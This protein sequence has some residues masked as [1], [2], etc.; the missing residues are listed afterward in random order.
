MAKHT[1]PKAKQASK[2]SSFLGLVFFLCCFFFLPRTFF[3]SGIANSKTSKIILLA[4]N[5]NDGSS[6]KSTLHS[7]A[8]ALSFTR[9][10]ELVILS[11]CCSMFSLAVQWQPLYPTILSTSKT[12]FR[13][14]YVASFPLN[15]FRKYSLKPSFLASSL[16]FLA[17]V[18][19]SPRSPRLPL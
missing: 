1:H 18:G 16:R 17:E 12:S 15:C 5:E 8:N 3:S 4:T 13:L 14:K 9:S 2:I 11:T 10:S 6:K 19:H 7:F